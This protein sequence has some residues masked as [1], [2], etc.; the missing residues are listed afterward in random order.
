MVWRVFWKGEGRWETLYTLSLYCC[1]NPWLCVQ[2]FCSPTAFL[3]WL[4]LTPVFFLSPSH[5]VL[6]FP[7][8]CSKLST[9][10][11]HKVFHRNSNAK[12]LADKSELYI[13]L[14]LD[15]SDSL[16]AQ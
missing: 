1:E 8:F 13:T 9:F 15:K 7:P 12:W 5:C 14:P 11:P 3:V 10:L 4:N 6:Y 2:L 16:F